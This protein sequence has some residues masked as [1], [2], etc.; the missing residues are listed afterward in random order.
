MVDIT[1]KIHTHTHTHKTYIWLY[2]YYIYLTKINTYIWQKLR[3]ENMRTWSKVLTE[4][5]ERST[6]TKWYDGLADQLMC[7]ISQWDK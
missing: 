5:V 4:G 2:I 6:Q 3:V 7:E 1:A